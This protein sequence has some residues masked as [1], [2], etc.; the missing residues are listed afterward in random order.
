MHDEAMQ[1][2]LK[3]A[4]TMQLEDK[5]VLEI[6]SYDVNGSPRS[7]FGKAVRYVGIDKT[8]GPG[9]DV[10][11]DGRI[12]DGKEEFDLCISTEAMEHD[13]EPWV[14]IQ[15]AWRSLKSGGKIVLTAAAPPR[16]PHSCGGGPVGGE[17]YTN[18]FPEYL[19]YML[20][21]WKDINVEYN[22]AHGDV[23]AIATKP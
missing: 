17:Y 20:K 6:G 19:S 4:A 21:E 2:L 12:Y 13:P 10:V 22:R 1:Y 16:H 7:A 8:P 18:I 11:S 14:I 15:C 23:Y 3:I 5:T 9:V